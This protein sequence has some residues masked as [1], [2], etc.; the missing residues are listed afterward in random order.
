MRMNITVLVYHVLLYCLRNPLLHIEPLLSLHAHYIHSS[1]S[2]IL[3][4]IQRQLIAH[5]KSLPTRLELDLWLVLEERVILRLHRLRQPI[6]LAF[7][8]QSTPRVTTSIVPARLC[9][10][11]HGIETTDELLL[12]TTEILLPLSLE[13]FSEAIVH[14]R[15]V[16]V[17]VV[18]LVLAVAPDRVVETLIAGDEAEGF[19]RVVFVEFRHLDALVPV[20]LATR[21]PEFDADV[22]RFRFAASGDGI[23]GV[24]DGCSVEVSAEGHTEHLQDRGC[25]VGVAVGHVCLYAL[26]DS[27]TT[28]EE[29]DV[30]GR[31]E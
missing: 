23:F 28:H 3:I 8:E 12:R 14:L 11:Q 10:E 1:L 13:A 4:R 15:K 7:R 16:V 25:H 30:E 5:N 22:L 31:E 19:V 24:W 2:A 20:R 6:D 27:G 26:R 9:H 18:E 21:I 17:H 29:R